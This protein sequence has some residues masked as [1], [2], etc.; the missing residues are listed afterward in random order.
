MEVLILFSENI[1]EEIERFGDSEA[2]NN[3]PRVSQLN[4][5]VVSE[6]TFQGLSND[7]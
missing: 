1:C 5:K 2:H 3:V 7:V 6:T 4:L